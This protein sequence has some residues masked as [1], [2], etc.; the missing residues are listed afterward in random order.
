MRTNEYQRVPTGTKR[1][2]RVPTGTSEFPLVPEGNSGYQWVPVQWV[3]VG[4]RSNK[5]TKTKSAVLPTSLMSFSYPR[6]LFFT[7]LGKNWQVNFLLD[8]EVVVLVE[9]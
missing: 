9:L 8:E 5:K 1:Y 4:T 2:Q 7:E 6:K 3:P